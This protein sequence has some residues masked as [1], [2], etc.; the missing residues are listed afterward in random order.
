MPGPPAIK[1]M[2]ANEILASLLG[3]ISAFFATFIGVFGIPFTNWPTGYLKYFSFS[4]GLEF[5][6]YVVV[7]F[8]SRR[9][10]M[11]VCWTLFVVDEIFGSLF[12][13]SER[14][15]P[16]ALLGKFIDVVVS[17]LPSLDIPCLLVALIATYLYR[18][19]KRRMEDE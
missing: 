19:E 13:L 12:V 14:S 7:F 16:N 2:Y 8:I 18:S 11:Y 9:L 4:L 17:A 15:M 3:L 10:L 5:P 6:A 1:K